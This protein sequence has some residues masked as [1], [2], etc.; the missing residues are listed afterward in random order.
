M[1]K[2]LF[3]SFLIVLFAVK[4]AAQDTVQYM[5][6]YYLFNERHPY[7]TIPFPGYTWDMMCR[8]TG[9]TATASGYN[10]IA[11]S[12][13]YHTPSQEPILVYGIAFTVEGNGYIMGRGHEE[14][15]ESD[16]DKYPYEAVISKIE[17]DTLDVLA[18]TTWN[19]ETDSRA[20][21]KYSI[22]GDGQLYEYVAPV[23]EYYFET[24]VLVYDTFYVGWSRLLSTQPYF[25]LYNLS[26]D[27]MTSY[28]I[29]NE[30]PL[31]SYDNHQQYLWGGVF[32]IIQPNRHCRVP[33]APSLVV[34]SGTNTVR[35]TLP[36]AAGDSLVLSIAG[37]GQPADSGT[38]Y[39]VTDSI[40]DIVI[41]DSGRYTARLMRICQRYGGVM[42][43]SDWSGPTHFFI[44]NNLAI[45]QPSDMGVS[46]VPNPATDAVT[47]SAD[48]T[49][50]T[51]ELRDLLGR[52][53]L[54][55]QPASTKT[56]V[57]V[58]TLPAGT[59]ILRLH[60]PQ[61]IATKKLIVK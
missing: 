1:K 49:L 40:M 42:L 56:T 41:P 13:R 8:F 38:V 33:A 19:Y 22:M 14:I 26:I 53:I 27:S 5:D 21:F 25:F 45:G 60:T 28:W 35:F 23:F 43:Q 7:T 58:S 54:T 51:L 10:T 44:V 15:K 55:Q 9:T 59:Y 61:G 47:V 50:L 52:T 18:T 32:P 39:P 17:G 16:I 2:T 30:R 20:Y 3:F 29:Q 12:S 37:Y 48:A 24:P 4:C 57:D 11:S 31:E 6:P 36:Y 34:Y 46:I